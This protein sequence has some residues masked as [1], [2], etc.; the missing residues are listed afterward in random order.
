MSTIVFTFGRFQPPT[1]GHRILINAVKHIAET[2]D[3]QYAVYVSRTQDKKTNPLPVTVKMQFLQKM[4]PETNFVAANDQVRTF[5]EAAI[6]L[7][8]T[9]DNLIM[10]AGSDR[11]DSYTSL[12]NKYN[13][14]E[15]NYNSIKV[16]SAGERDPDSDSV[17]G[18]S[19]TKMREAALANNIAAFKAGVLGLDDYDAQQLMQHVQGLVPK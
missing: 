12:L 13:G 2:N 4:F 10:V 11:V 16:I 19:G 15:F 8:K 1:I 17:S 3:A 18:M 7:N 9:F 6:D 5:M 14:V